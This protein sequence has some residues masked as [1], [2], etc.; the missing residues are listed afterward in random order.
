MTR[1][2]IDENV[3]QKALRA[4]PA[5]EKGF[6]ILFPD[7]AG[8]LSQKDRPVRLCALDQQRTLVTG[9]SDFNKD[10]LL[11]RHFPFGVVWIRPVRT[12]QKLVGVL[13]ERFCKLLVSKFPS[14][15][16]N[17]Q[18]KI[19]EITDDQVLIVSEDDEQA[20]PLPYTVH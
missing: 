13:I 12:S 18:N 7:R 20:F 3:N 17:F 10:Q 15:P 1:F 19:V 4:I 14:D 16:Y 2:L 5:N 6:D 8:I 11:P 9:D